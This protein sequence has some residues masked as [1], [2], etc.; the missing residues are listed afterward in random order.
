MAAMTNHDRDVFLE[1]EAQEREAAGMPPY[2]RLA[3]IIVSGKDEQ[4]VMDVAQALGVCAP[5][6]EGIQTLGPAEAAF[7]RLR[8]NYRRRLLVRAPKKIKF[9]KSVGGLGQ[10]G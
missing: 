3:G 6:G 4:A 7:Y 5:Q 8:G 9:A 10:P 1:V 2:S